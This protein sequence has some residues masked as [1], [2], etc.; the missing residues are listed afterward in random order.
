MATILAPPKSLYA[1]RIQDIIPFTTLGYESAS[2]C[3]SPNGWQF[4]DTVEHLERLE[5]C[6]SMET[7]DAATSTLV[8]P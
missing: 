8:R 2:A 5:T 7:Y 1:S 3:K 6:I 4:S